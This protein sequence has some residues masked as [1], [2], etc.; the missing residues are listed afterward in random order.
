MHNPISR[1]SLLR[2]ALFLGLILGGAFPTGLAAQA[3]GS[4]GWYTYENL[5]LTHGDNGPSVTCMFPGED[6]VGVNFRT[7]RR[8]RGPLEEREGALPSW[9]G[10]LTLASGPVSV[11]LPARMVPSERDGLVTV[12]AKL[13]VNEPVLAEFRST[14]QITV[15]AL[16]DRRRPPRAP[17][18]AVAAV[19]DTCRR[20]P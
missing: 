9:A 2:M 14:G 18:D 8:P 7:R 13:H 6:T 5:S 12:V 4:N 16:G 17:L 10:E 19:L 20:G 3:R 15:S 1:P 11:N